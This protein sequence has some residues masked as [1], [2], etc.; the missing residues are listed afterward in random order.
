MENQLYNE[1]LSSHFSFH[2]TVEL[3][4]YSEVAA[5]A[6]VTWQR[7]K[8]CIQ[9]TVSLLSG[10]LKNGEN[11]AFVLKDV[12]VLLFEGMSFGIKYYYDFLEKLSGKEKFRKVVFKVSWRFLHGPGSPVTLA[13]TAHGPPGPGQLLGLCRCCG[14]VSSPCLGLLQS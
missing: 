6:S 3:L 5:A 11:V 8:T 1:L 4:K 14:G 13:L 9:S 2:R 10:C 12:G 7:G